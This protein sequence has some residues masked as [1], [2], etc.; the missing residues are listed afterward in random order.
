MADETKKDSQVLRSLEKGDAIR[1]KPYILMLFHVLAPRP[2][3]AKFIIVFLNFIWQ[4]LNMNCNG[5]KI[6]RMLSRAI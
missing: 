4:A 2:I 3:K 6:F 1:R 5:I